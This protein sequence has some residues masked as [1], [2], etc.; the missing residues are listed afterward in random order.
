[1]KSRWVRSRA[2]C[3]SAGDQVRSGFGHG[4]IK[5]ATAVLILVCLSKQSGLRNLQL[6][7]LLVVMKYL[8]VLVSCLGVVACEGHHRGLIETEPSLSVRGNV[9]HAQ[10][11]EIVYEIGAG[12]TSGCCAVTVDLKN[13][14][15]AALEIDL[16]KAV[17]GSSC[18]TSH[19]LHPPVLHKGDNEKSFEDLKRGL[20]EPGSYMPVD[21]AGVVRITGEH[22]ARIVF[23]PKEPWEKQCLPYRF[24]LPLPSG[25]LVKATF[26]DFE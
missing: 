7:S 18:A 12:G 14:K 1:M 8:G 5:P 4:I 11:S 17:I 6:G 2:R 19:Q 3:R 10:N 16:G 26:F 13:V 25:F 23:S 20:Y 9:G 22:V 21:K 24:Q 15:S